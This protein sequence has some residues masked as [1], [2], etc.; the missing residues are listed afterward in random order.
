M[1]SSASRK[2]IDPGTE[3]EHGYIRSGG[4]AQFRKELYR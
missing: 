1:R 2:V 4:K 3:D